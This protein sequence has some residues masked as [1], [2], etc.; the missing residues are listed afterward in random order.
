L[1][2][3]QHFYSFSFIERSWIKTTEKE[4]GG[5][6]RKLKIVQVF[7]NISLKFSAMAD[8]EGLLPK[9]FKIAYKLGEGVILWEEFRINEK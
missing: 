3:S 4:G 7:K 6:S 9:M 8:F 5:R 1:L 2:S